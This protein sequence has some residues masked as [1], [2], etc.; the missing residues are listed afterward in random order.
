MDDRTVRYPE[1][2][3]WFP[4]SRT[5]R[6]PDT[7][8]RGGIS[9]RPCSTQGQNIGFVSGGPR[10]TRD[11]AVADA[12]TVQLRYRLINQHTTE[13]RRTAATVRS[14]VQ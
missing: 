4:F 5:G 12:L 1:G 10:P 14:S 3:D 13:R 11:V 2:L 8:S 9:S 6:L 7:A